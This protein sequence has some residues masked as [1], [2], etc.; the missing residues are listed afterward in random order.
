MSESSS[1][2]GDTLMFI[3]VLSVGAFIFIATY[4]AQIILFLG[5]ALL[6]AGLGFFV[7]GSV[8]RLGKRWGYVGVLELAIVAM[9]FRFLLGTPF[10][11][12][13]WRG[14][15]TYVGLV[16]PIAQG[17]RD[18]LW[19]VVAIVTVVAAF[20]WPIWRA[21]QPWNE[22]SEKVQNEATI[23]W[24]EIAELFFWAPE[25]FVR[26][27]FSGRAFA[28]YALMALFSLGLGILGYYLRVRAEM[29]TQVLLNGAILLWVISLFRDPLLSSIKEEEFR[30][31]GVVSKRLAMEE[32]QKL[33]G[34]ELDERM[35]IEAELRARER[36]ASD[37]KYAKAR[38]LEEEKEKLLREAIE[39]AR[40]GQGKRTDL[41]PI[42]EKDLRDDDLF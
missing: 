30:I 2:R 32:S 23:G 34:Q 38:K 19:L 27:Y 14:V 17:F 36:E 40:P 20:L 5:A 16:A 7:S 8:R 29:A 22:E 13:S 41:I 24:S 6:G 31:E 4:F 39:E 18:V 21:S 26:R 37:A 12:D 42:N 1:N 25:E 15:F 3:L 28:P 10:S 11:F 9:F 33:A 35:R